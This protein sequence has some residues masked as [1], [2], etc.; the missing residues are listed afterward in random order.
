MVEKDFPRHK[1]GWNEKL[2]APRRIT[3]SVPEEQVKS[4]LK[5]YLRLAKRLGADGAKVVRAQDVIVQERVQ[6]KCLV[7]I[8]YRYGNSAFC[9]P[10]APSPERVEKAI[11]QYTYAVLVKH[12][13]SPKEDFVVPGQ[14]KEWTLTIGKHHGE[15]IKIVSGVESAAFNDGYYLAM[16]F[17]GGTCKSSLCKGAPCARLQGEH[18]RFPLL[19]RPSMEA[20]GIDVFNI[21]A[22][23]GWEIYP[24]GP[25]N[26]PTEQVPCALSVGIVF[27]Y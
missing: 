14:G 5:K 17:G 19:A 4:D 1:A 16:G 3:L 11:R 26:V 2:S 13:V 15:V 10:H 6:L 12:V 8:C 25:K 9:P 18:C 27:I 23:A 7:P 24:I 20:V 22:K 21:A